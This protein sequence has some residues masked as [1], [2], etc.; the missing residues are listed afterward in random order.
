LHHAVRTGL[1]IGGREQIGRAV[2][3]DAH[4]LGGVEHFGNGVAER[5]HD[6]GRATF[7]ELQ[8]AEPRHRK[9]LLG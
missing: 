6:R 4:L 5:L 7:E 9:A 8:D 2:E 3:A 1:G